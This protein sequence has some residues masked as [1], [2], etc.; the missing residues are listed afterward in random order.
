MPAILFGS[1]GTIAET[2]ELQRQAF[3]RA[4]ERHGL[5]WHWNREEY[6]ALLQKSGGRQRI[7]AY[8]RSLGQ[9]VDAAAIHQSKSE[10]FQQSMASGQLQPRAGVVQTVQAAKQHDLKVGLVTTTSEF[11]VHALLKAL[12]DRLSFEDFDIVVTSAQVQ[13]AKPAAAAYSLALAQLREQPGE[14]LAIEDNVDGLTAAKSAG[15]ACIAFPGA[16]TAHHDFSASLFSTDH[17]DFAT[18]KQFLPA[19]SSQLRG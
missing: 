5:T 6:A 13:H 4:F 7:A 16:N 11:N 10:I 14:C 18:L 19:L 8:G 15:I 9:S 2:S 12:G 1:I 3:N 17:L